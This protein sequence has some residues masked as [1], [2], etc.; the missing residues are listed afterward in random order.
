MS[1]THDPNRNPKRTLL[2]I[3]PNAAN[4]LL[5][6]KLIEVRSNFK[7]LKAV[8]GYQGVQKAC[9]HMPDL[10]LLDINL[11]DINGIEVMK[12]LRE[13]PETAHIPVIVLSSDAYQEQIEEG[14]KAGCIRYLTKPYKINDLMDAI[15]VGLNDTK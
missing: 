4:F 13:N 7:L 6:K 1:G 11:P 8:N 5:V 12:L 14:L 9:S 15:D 10:I 2:Y 3:E